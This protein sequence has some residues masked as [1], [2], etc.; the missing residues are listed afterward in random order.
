MK[1]SIIS[2]AAAAV[3][4]ISAQSWA[5]EATEPTEPPP[6]ETDANFRAFDF[7]LGE[8]DVSSRANGQHAGVNVIE[9]AENGCALV[10]HWTGRTGGTGMSVNYYNPVTGK[11]R[12][13]WVAAG[14]YSLEIEGNID[15]GSMFLEG[16]IYYYRTARKFDFRGRWTPNDDGSVRQQFHQYNPE[17]EVWDDWFDG[18]YVKKE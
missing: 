15:D 17:T 8:W 4:G 2:I 12:Q 6:C 18:L 3:A 11:W 16:E 7:W 14:N 9:Q 1:Y 5:Q 13:I 10:E